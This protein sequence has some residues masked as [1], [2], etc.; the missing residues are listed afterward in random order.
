MRFQP[1]LV[2]AILIGLTACAAG[3]KPITTPA[4]KQ[5]YLISC[6]GSADDWSTCYE[7]SIK[8]CGGPYN[9]VDRNESS[10]PTAYGPL[11]R[12]NMIVECKR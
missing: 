9:V 10:T 3:V 7:A 11:V 1:V 4:G 8:A 5:G 2:V 12:R 6:D